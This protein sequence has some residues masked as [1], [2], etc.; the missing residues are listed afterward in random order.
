VSRTI[1]AGVLAAAFLV[2][3]CSG[4]TTPTPAGAG[5]GTP[6][7]TPVTTAAATEP[8]SAATGTTT[9]A[10]AA[11]LAARLPASVDGAAFTVSSV[12]MG[13]LAGLTP[14][15]VFGDAT[16]MDP[17]LTKQGKTWK[18]VN[19]AFAVTAST[20][21]TGFVYAIQVKG[22]S[23]DAMLEWFGLSGIMGGAGDTVTIDGKSVVKYAVPGID[24]TYFAWV[25]GDTLFWIIGAKP[26][27]F[28]ED[29]VKAVH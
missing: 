29:I 14:E 26:A 6:T 7:P 22:V 5:N 27:S 15:A 1:T 8:S 9:G 24:M 25:S 18:D 3:A 17:W 20:T 11:E 28:G 21:T 23:S 4:G 2:A 19:Y 16:T 13:D 12:S 10:G